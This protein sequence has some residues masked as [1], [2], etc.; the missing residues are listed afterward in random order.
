MRSRHPTHLPGTVA[1][2]FYDATLFVGGEDRIIRGGASLDDLTYSYDHVRGIQTVGYSQSDRVFRTAE[3]H[4]PLPAWLHGPW[5]GIAGARWANPHADE[6]GRP[7]EAG[8]FGHD[9][10]RIRDFVSSGQIDLI[11]EEEVCGVM[12]L[13]V[14]MAKPQSDV[15]EE[16]WFSPDGLRLR[17]RAFEG[18]QLVLEDECLELQRDYPLTADDFQY[19][20]PPNARKATFMTW[21][22]SD[23]EQVTTWWLADNV[24]QLADRP[25]GLRA[26]GGL[27]A[28]V[29]VEGSLHDH[30]G[31]MI[32]QE[33]QDDA[34]R[35]WWLVEADVDRWQPLPIIWRNEGWLP[36]AADVGAVRLVGEYLTDY[37]L[38]TWYDPTRR[39]R[40][41]LRPP[42]S[43][44]TATL[45]A[46]AE[47]V[48]AA[49]VWPDHAG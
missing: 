28:T 13:G 41:V 4:A 5:S 40:F 2:T 19:E 49:V 3:V 25:A 47:T 30:P 33:L 34:G 43:T 46:T 10:N 35:Q 44:P 7:F 32:V 37:R 45:L 18:R 39:I 23:I 31:W 11:G 24:V 38:A 26:V 16:A 36:S 48:S 21:P 29:E 9:V 27:V 1:N 15:T 12:A 22:L 42:E 20:P 14:A 6:A 17:A 8:F